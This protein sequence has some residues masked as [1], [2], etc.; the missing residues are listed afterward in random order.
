MKKSELYALAMACVIK[1]DY[2]I[3]TQCQVDILCLL[4]SDKHSAEN[5]EKWD[6]EQAA[7]EK[8]E[9]AQKA[10]EEAENKKNAFMREFARKAYEKYG[11]DPSALRGTS[12]AAAGEAKD[13]GGAE[14]A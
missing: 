5:L 1:T 10:K 4:A 11:E 12:P 6:A 9:E 13:E 14:N 8:A 7:R 3:T 2:G